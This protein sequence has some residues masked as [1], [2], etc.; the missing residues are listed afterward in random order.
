MSPPDQYP[1][2]GMKLS[3]EEIDLQERRVRGEPITKAMFNQAKARTI[4]AYWA[5]MS[6]PMP[7]DAAFFVRRW[8]GQNPADSLVGKGC[9]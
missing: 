1:L 2:S 3:S 8:I 4:Q 5:S 9:Y 6:Q 7:E